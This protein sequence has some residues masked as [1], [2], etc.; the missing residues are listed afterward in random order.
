[1][2]NI[3]GY[4][5]GDMERKAI[6]AAEEDA[7]KI[8]AL[9]NPPPVPVKKEDVYV[10]RCR[11]VSDAVDYSYGRFRTEDLPRLLNLIEG[12]SLIIGH[13]KDTVGV[14]RFFNGGMETLEDVYNPF[15][16]KK[17]RITYCVPKF[18]WM[19]KHSEADDLR[20]NIDGGIYHQVSLSWW[21]KKA[22]CGICGKDMRECEHVPGREYSGVT[23]FYYYD[24]IGDV[25]EGSIVYKGG[26]PFTGFHLNKEL[27][28]GIEE[29]GRIYSIYSQNPPIRVFCEDIINYLK[30]L[31]GSASIV[32]DIVQRGYAKGRIDIITDSAKTDDI[33]NLLPLPFKRM[34]RFIET[35]EVNDAAVRVGSE[36]L[37]NTAQSNNAEN[38]ED[39]EA[40]K[41]FSKRDFIKLTGT[42]FVEPLY[43][44]VDVRVC[45]RNGEVKIL[46]KSGNDVSEKAAYICE[47]IKHF[48]EDGLILNGILLAYH[49]R[50]R[51]GYNEVSG[52]IYNNENIQNAKLRL[53]V[54]DFE[55]WGNVDT[56]EMPLKN[57]KSL[58]VE[59][60]HD[61]KYVQMIKGQSGNNPSEILN[62]ID[63]C[64]TKDG[65]VVKNEMSM[66]NEKDKW[67]I[68]NKRFVINALVAGCDNKENGKEYSC[69]LKTAGGIKIIG[70]VF[71][72]SVAVKEG[73][74]VVLEI[75][76]AEFNDN[77][78]TLH[79]PK[80]LYAKYGEQN[81]DDIECLRRIADAVNETDFSYGPPCEF[82]LYEY[83]KKGERIFE[84]LLQDR[85]SDEYIKFMR[86]GDFL[87]RND[88]MSLVQMKR[89]LGSIPAESKII[90]YGYILDI[91]NS[92]HFKQFSLF[93]R[94]GEVK[95]SFTAREIR[96]QKENSFLL[97]PGRN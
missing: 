97:Y 3:L 12:V 23:G 37:Q 24:E 39:T 51:L 26:Q 80:L 2:K 46:D 52:I 50:T 34:V 11:L 85:E 40:V 54:Y 74:I 60:F 77:A 58:L 29:C 78:V 17:E 72:Q 48:S 47:E 33:I 22:T 73:D 87:F 86:K 83:E 18:Y 93:G 53:K 70:S 15:T 13:R 28:S 62:L 64:A 8:N 94:F 69:S 88:S 41:L 1:M 27:N 66:R 92:A 31:K 71:S 65:A 30:P 81:A 36:V 84:L 57:R 56:A 9:S 96:Y 90:D 38:V 67:Y 5:Y 21:Y 43:R 76:N 7:E 95:D 91:H 20:I 61:T 32:G 44:G 59:L 4:I 16:Q 55:R 25:L 19:K 6:T 79:M 14:A 10:R 75:E 45:K 89:S 42:H 63:T 68:Y 82:M 49:G 35:D